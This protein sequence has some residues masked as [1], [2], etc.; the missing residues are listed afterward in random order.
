[1][2]RVNIVNPL[3]RL[4]LV[5]RRLELVAHV[6]A[7]DH[8]D[9]SLELNFSDGLRS[10]LVVA[11]IDMARLQRPSECPRQSARGRCYNVIQRGGMRRVGIWRD[12]VVFGDLGMDAEHYRFFLA[13]K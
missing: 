3:N 4:P 9:V 1:M 12:L 8:K 11:G 2:P 13:G 5:R 7:P 6:N 10:K